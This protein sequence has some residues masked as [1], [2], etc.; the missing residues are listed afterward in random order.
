M[1]GKWK[2]MSWGHYSSLYFLPGTNNNLPFPLLFS[3]CP[4]QP[5]LNR[6][7]LLA[8]HGSDTILL[9]QNTFTGN[10]WNSP[11]SANPAHLELQGDY[12]VEQTLKV[13][14]RFQIVF[15]PRSAWETDRLEESPAS[16]LKPIHLSPLSILNVTHITQGDLKDILNE[17]WFS[18]I[19]WE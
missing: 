8:D 4:L 12:T 10:Q 3:F 15:K 18:P 5:A 6:K 16:W 13:F 2:C 17:Q 9:I 19:V 1:Y 11:K 14:E 7:A